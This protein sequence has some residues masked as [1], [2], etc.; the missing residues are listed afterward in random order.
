MAT[1]RIVV[2]PTLSSRG[3]WTLGLFQLVPTKAARQQV[4]AFPRITQF[5]AMVIPFK[6]SAGVFQPA[7]DT[8]RAP[9]VHAE[10]GPADGAAVAAAPTLQELAG[11]LEVNAAQFGARGIPSHA[12]VQ[13]DRPVGRAAEDGLAAVARGVMPKRMRIQE[14]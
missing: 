5:P 8:V 7:A 11:R 10:P 4:Q 9:P 12:D 6:T 3:T 1:A 2:I 14:F 13:A